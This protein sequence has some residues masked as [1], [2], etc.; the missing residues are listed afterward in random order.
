MVPTPLTKVHVPVPVVG[1]F[2]AIV[3]VVEQTVWFGP[4]A[5]VV[6]AVTPVIVTVDE[7]G[8]QGEFEIVH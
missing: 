2:P 3:A 4:A 8:V 5:A 6:G 7:E 1:V